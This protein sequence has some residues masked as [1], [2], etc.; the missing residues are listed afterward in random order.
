[1]GYENFLDPP[2]SGL[3]N[4]NFGFFHAD[5]AGAEDRVLFGNQVKN[6]IEFPFEAPIIIE[7]VNALNIIP[8]SPGQ[9]RDMA[10]VLNE[11]PRVKSR[12]P[13]HFRPELQRD[14]HGMNVQ[15][16]YGEV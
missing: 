16:S 7:Q 4:G 8:D 12:E 6:G 9:M 11:F 15:P 10:L 1:M 13:D 3:S 5:V 2:L 14:I